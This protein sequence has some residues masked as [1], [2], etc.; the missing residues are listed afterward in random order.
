M[1]STIRTLAAS[2]VLAIAASAAAA[3]TVGIATGPQAT[4]TNATGSAIAKVINEATGLQTRA[5]PHTSN[6]VAMPVL[7]RAQVDFAIASVDLADTAFRGVEQFDGRKLGNVRIVA[8]L[9]P[10]NVGIVVRKDSNIRTIPELK[11]KRYPSE[12]T[13]QKGVVKVAAALLANGGLGY[14]DVAGI[15]VPNTS[16]GGEDFVQGKS[17]SAMLALG[18][19]RL[20][21]TDAQVG[22][23]RIL[24]IDT[25]PAAMARMKKLMPH[26]Y[27]YELKAGVLP[28]AD[29]MTSIMSY[30]LLLVAA[31]Q[32]KDDVVYKAV[33]SMH[34]G[35]AKLIAVTPLFR[36]FDP[37]KMHTGY[38]GLSYHPGAVKYYKEA[39]VALVN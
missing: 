26:A 1:M 16:R 10:L 20:K 27:A 19:A 29:T 28:G 8:R 23:I 17:D 13:A 7:N 31:A 33:K 18:A 21:Q 9:F 5:V 6:D 38:A 25:S 39:G 30:D 11:G 15:P 12:F 35:K 32:T 37:A 2:A 24:P 34:E 3:Q 14:Q 36:D 22:G 4:P